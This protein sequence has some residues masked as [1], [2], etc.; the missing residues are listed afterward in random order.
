MSEKKP[1]IPFVW[2]ILA[3]MLLGALLGALLGERAAPLGQVGTTV[4][5]LIK[6]MAAPLL[7][8][9]ILDA[10]LSTDLRGRDG[11]KLVL[12]NGANG[13]IAVGIGLLI[14]NVFEPGKSLVPPTRSGGATQPPKLDFLE[15]LR[16]YVPTNFFRP[17]VEDALVTIILLGIL[18]GIALRSAKNEQIGAREA[19]YLPLEHTIQTLYR[20]NQIAIAWIVKLVPLAVA[21]VVAKTIGEQGLAPLRGL[22]V[23]VAAALGGLL[24]H[25]LLVYQSWIVLVVKM[26]LRAFWNGAKEAVVYAL[27]ASSSLATLPVTLKSLEK[28]GVSRESSTLAAC[29]G[30]NLNNDGILLYEAMAAIFVAQAYGIDLS[31]HQQLVI[32]GSCVIA[33]IGISGIPDAGLISLS[34]VMGTVGLPVEILPLLLTVDWL[35]SRVRAATNVTCD[36]L[37]AVLLDRFAKPRPAP[38][39]A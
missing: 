16:G 17:F 26:P 35:I 34:L 27:G 8:L 37:V 29:V 30:T 31:L 10:F 5:A 14:A 12:I 38:V 2:Q 36:I 28:M 21:S 11:L 23:Y 33:G 24:L 6:S 19:R 39:N 9:A 4:I 18:T 22:S 13:T 15:T 7:F 20:A 3:A 1:K 25:V 32:A